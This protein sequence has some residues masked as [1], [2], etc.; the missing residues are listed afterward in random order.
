M[1]MSVEHHE[2]LRHAVRAADRASVMADLADEQATDMEAEARELRLQAVRE[3][4]SVQGHV[5]TAARLLHA[6]AGVQGG[7]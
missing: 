2:A 6:P 1:T 5:A 4:A 7:A 3:R